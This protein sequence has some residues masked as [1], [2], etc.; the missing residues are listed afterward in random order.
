MPPLVTR[1]KVAVVK[2]FRFS[3]NSNKLFPKAN[4][5][6]E[7]NDQKLFDDAEPLSRPGRMTISH[8]QV[9]FKELN[10]RKLPNQLKFFSGGNSGDGSEFKM[11]TM[12]KIGMLNESNN[13]FLEH[14]TT[15]Y[16]HE[17]LA[18]KMKI[19][20]ET[21]NILL[22]QYKHAYRRT[23]MIFYLRSRTKQK[24]LWTIMK[25]IFQATLTFI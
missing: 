15:D 19:H 23:F 20:L 8:K 17:I 22:Q 11:L 5:V 14:L 21:G 6:F 24:N 7:N 3:E 4:A 2:K 25:L 12:E 16:A 13:A 10:E 1:E 18:K 9:M